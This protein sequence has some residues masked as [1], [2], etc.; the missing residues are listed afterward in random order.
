MRFTIRFA[1]R[2]VRGDLYE[3]STV[4]ETRQFL[5]ALA[6]EAAHRGIDRV[7][8]SVHSSTAI[9]STQQFGLPAFLE[10]LASR[11]A[12]RI[13]MIA[14]SWEVQ[15]A[16]Q[17]IAMFARLRGLAVRSFRNQNEAVVWLEARDFSE[18]H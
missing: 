5:V 11:P 7:L 14:D 18:S 1:P 9:F 12:H 6:S 13:A 15:L 17:Y 10:L 8:I 2:Y 3:R 16:H 4:E